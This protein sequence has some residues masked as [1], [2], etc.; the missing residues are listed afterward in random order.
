[1]ETSETLPTKFRR[2]W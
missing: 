1:M 2:R